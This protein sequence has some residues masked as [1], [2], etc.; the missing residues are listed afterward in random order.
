MKTSVIS[1]MLALFLAACTT[2][3]EGARVSERDIPGRQDIREQQVRFN[4]SPDD[5][6]IIRRHRLKDAVRKPPVERWVPDSDNGIR[7][8]AE[9]A[10]KLET[11]LVLMLN[12]P[13]EGNS[14]Q[15]EHRGSAGRGEVRRVIGLDKESREKCRMD[16]IIFGTDGQWNRYSFEFCK[17]AEE[18]WVVTQSR[19]RFTG[20][21][22][23]DRSA[24]ES[25][26]PSQDA[27]G[28]TAQTIAE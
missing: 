1:V 17:L 22:F 3:G 18:I 5:G 11:A 21:D 9:E 23:S 13:G 26:S 7:L 10:R 4:L 19:A 15:W 24:R 12:A 25:N 16:R 20:D 28:G 27:R 2:T 8:T 14:P 6:I